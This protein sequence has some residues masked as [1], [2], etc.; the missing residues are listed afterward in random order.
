[1]VIVSA[2]SQICDDY[3]ITL[4]NVQEFLDG[5]MLRQTENSTLMIYRQIASDGTYQI[6][7]LA[8]LSVE[9]CK[10]NV[11]KKHESITKVTER[12]PSN[13]SRT[14][15]V[16]FH[17]EYVLIDQRKKFII[18]YLFHPIGRNYMWTQ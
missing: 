15:H 13:K 2:G 4:R 14:Y 3:N 18:A 16:S 12:P 9:D 10:A 11:V 6:G 17:L 1:M 5:G 8:A 7:V